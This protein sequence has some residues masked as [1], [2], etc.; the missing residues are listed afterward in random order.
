MRKEVSR[1]I[2]TLISKA[3]EEERKLMQDDIES[4]FN[5]SLS[6]RSRKFSEKHK[7]AISIHE[8][9]FGSN[10]MHCSFLKNSEHITSMFDPALRPI[11]S[12]TWGPLS[13]KQLREGKLRK[14]FENNHGGLSFLQLQGVM[15]AIKNQVQTIKEL[16]LSENKQLK[17]TIDANETA[18]IVQSYDMLFKQLFEDFQTI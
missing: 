15:V 17:F 8:D 9:E 1:T 5:R 10:F 14:L 2:K 12:T 16:K 18:T 13:S 11:N 4:G 6:S 7:R 3:I